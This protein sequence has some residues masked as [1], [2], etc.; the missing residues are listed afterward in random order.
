MT[1]TMALIIVI[2]LIVLIWGT[3]YL[4][5]HEQLP[6]NLRNR[7]ENLV[8]GAQYQYHKYVTSPEQL[9]ERTI[10][11]TFDN[12]AKLALEKSLKKESMHSHNEE[13]CHLSSQNTG[14]AIQTAYILGNLYN[15][16]APIEPA[17]YGR[18]SMYFNRALSRI[19][20]NPIAAT[21][22]STPVESMIDR[23]QDF[24]EQPITVGGAAEIIAPNDRPNFPRLRH[25]VRQAR[26]VNAQIKTAAK[27]ILPPKIMAI[28]N[29]YQERPLPNDP[30][31]VHDSE[32]NEELGTLYRALVAKNMHTDKPLERAE[33]VVTDEELL[34]EI[35]KYI[36]GRP[37]ESR[38]RPIFQRMQEA[39]TISSL[40]TNERRILLETWKRTHA[41]INVKANKVDDLRAAIVQG[42]A[43]CMESRELGK[44]SEV[45]VTGRC[46]RVLGALTLIDADQTLS[47]PLKTQAVLRKEAFAAAYRIIND[48]LE[49]APNNIVEQYQGFKPITDEAAVNKLEI[50]LHKEIDTGLRQ[51]YSHVSSRVLDPLIKDAQAGI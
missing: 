8:N 28:E 25:I 38:A 22:G 33:H 39:A 19:L 24:Y 50:D 18:A 7:Y 43:D 31:N 40:G 41:P 2:I 44:W 13:L 23:V 29:Y 46:G 11:Y 5:N 17:N 37:E 6:S 12:N 34:Q 16:N 30:Q 47:T 14:D 51:I 3:S 20:T 49:A 27:S 10:G 42:L 45:C 32:F 4:Y 15:Y 26:V 21:D 35:D 48:T 36:Q 9:Y 1:F